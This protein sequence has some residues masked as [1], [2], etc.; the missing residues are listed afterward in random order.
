MKPGKWPLVELCLGSATYN[1]RNIKITPKPWVQGQVLRPPSFVN[2]SCSVLQE[3]GSLWVHGVPPCFAQH[4]PLSVP[5][6]ILII[7]WAPD[8][9][10]TTLWVLE[11]IKSDCHRTNG[12]SV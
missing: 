8:V 2:S 3:L 10:L 7:P 6:L 5:Y 11:F 1:L 12:A 9:K 4:H